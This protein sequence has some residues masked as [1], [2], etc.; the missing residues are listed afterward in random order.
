MLTNELKDFVNNA[1]GIQQIKKE[2]VFHDSH[3]PSRVSGLSL[4]KAFKKALPPKQ[5]KCNGGPGKIY[6]V[7]KKNENNHSFALLCDLSPTFKIFRAGMV[8]SG[9]NFKHE[10]GF[11]HAGQPRNGFEEIY[12]NTQEEVE[13]HVANLAAA[14]QKAE[15]EL[16]DVLLRLYGKSIV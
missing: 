16:T 11:A 1:E 14:L 4:A 10:I 2:W 13:Y 6:T 3:S 15:T 12:P 8:I 9:Y 5:Y 7:E